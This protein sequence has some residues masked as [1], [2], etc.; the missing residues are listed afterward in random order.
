MYTSYHCGD[1]GSLICKMT[2]KE[3]FKNVAIVSA[4]LLNDGFENLKMDTE[5]F[6]RQRAN[7]MPEMQGWHQFQEMI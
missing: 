7:W 1:C 6:I 4:G 3:V 2:E 5:L